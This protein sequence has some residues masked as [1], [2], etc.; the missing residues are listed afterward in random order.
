MSSLISSFR[1]KGLNDFRAQKEL[2]SLFQCQSFVFESIARKKLEVLY[3]HAIFFIELEGFAAFQFVANFTCRL[4]FLFMDA[5]VQL[6]Y[7]SLR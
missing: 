1:M 6:L 5:C 3:I 4:T 7:T 2:S